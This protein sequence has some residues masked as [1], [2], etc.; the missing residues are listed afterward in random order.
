MSVDHMMVDSCNSPLCGFSARLYNVK[1]AKYAK[2]SEQHR[3]QVKLVEEVQCLG[4]EA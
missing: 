1:Y 2:D 3:L 4:P